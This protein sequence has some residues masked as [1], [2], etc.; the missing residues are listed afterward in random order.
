MPDTITILTII[1]LAATVAWS[2]AWVFKGREAKVLAGELGRERADFETRLA[3]QSRLTANREAEL[4][5]VRA[6]VDE[7]Q[8]KLT[9][10][11]E[12]RARLNALHESIT[13]VAAQH[14]EELAR[15]RAQ[16]VDLEGTR[17]A[18]RDQAS[19]LQA[20]LARLTTAL[21]QERRAH[22]D[23]TVAARQA[24]AEMKASL[25]DA[26]HARDGARER[27]AALES[28]IA[29]LTTLQ[30]QERLAHQEK[31]KV[32]QAAEEQFRAAVKA[33]AADALTAN[34]EAFLTLAQEKLGA[35]QKVAAG[36]FEQKQKTIQ[37]LV[38]PVATL[39]EKLQADIKV[40]EQNRVETR[41]EII[42]QVRQVAELVPALQKETSQLARSLRHSG[43]R[44][45]WGELQLRKSL[46]LAGLV[47]GL[48]YTFQARLETAD[49]HLIPDVIVHLPGGGNIV[50]DAKTPMQAFLDAHATT[51]EDARA[52][53][54]EQ[55]LSAVRQHTVLLGGK[56]YAAQVTPSPDFVVMYVPVEAAL[57]EA[58][59]A[60]VALLED[61][62]NRDVMLAGPLVLIALLRTVAFGWRQHHVAERA[63]DIAA[64]GGELHDRIATVVERV[65]TLGRRLDRTVQAY[66]EASASFESR[67][68][69]GARRL[70]DLHVKT[71]KTVSPM[72][73]IERRSRLI[74]LPAPEAEI[75]NPVEQSSTD[76]EP[77]LELAASL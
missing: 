74:A 59:G 44:G 65:A 52:R 34:N 45:Q 29:R 49:G 48:H 56:S 26:T 47:E 20:D 23:W 5:A 2:L 32:Y 55:H 21:D 77:P 63:E 37:E 30:E 22:N 66:N 7:L 28:E 71:T 17:D 13:S 75:V 70:R 11:S 46:E 62:A 42:A 24:E 61:A 51:D 4:A 19:V 72:P 68:V 50:I 31:L 53:Y 76:L 54:M 3:D 36:D 60:D 35:L 57:G 39:L 64:L 25:A 41:T 69:P 33:T 10:I 16:I 6:S 18:A 38:T 58:L 8:A 1:F 40:A 15:L 27:I 9:A 67:L 43:T 12:E 73:Q 14:S